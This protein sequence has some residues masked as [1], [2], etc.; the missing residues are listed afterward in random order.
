[1]GAI[2]PHELGSALFGPYLLGVELAS[3]VLL[4][5]LIGA[6]H[7]GRRYRRDEMEERRDELAE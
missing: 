1:M 3:M 4:A 7:L 2:Q 6:Y 5:G